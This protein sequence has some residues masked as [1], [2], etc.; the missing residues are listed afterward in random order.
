VRLFVGVELEAAARAAAAEA[1]RALRA[2]LDD[3]AVEA[4]WIDEPNLHITL[5]F[6]G[7]VG[8]DRV[9]AV[10]RALEP[11]AP[12]RP[13]TLELHG[14]GAFPPSGAPRVFWLGVGQGRSGLTALYDVV[15]ARLEPLGFEAGTRPYAPHLTLARVRE[16]RRRSGGRQW[17]AA[18]DAPTPAIRSRVDHVTLFRSHLSPKGARYEPLL[19]VPLEG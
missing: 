10:Q 5:W 2:R 19:R 6:L 15:R 14:V 17:R 7:E 1:G 13:F 11:P 12:V 18:L 4:R 8:D 9:S 3:R 16:G